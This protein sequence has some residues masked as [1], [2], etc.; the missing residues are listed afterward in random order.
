[1]GQAGMTERADH[2]YFDEDQF[3]DIE[4][5]TVLK[6]SFKYH[7]LT[8]HQNDLNLINPHI[9]ALLNARRVCGLVISFKVGMCI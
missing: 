2:R 5:L 9:D 6:I 3:T 1:L 8:S 7:E 4:R